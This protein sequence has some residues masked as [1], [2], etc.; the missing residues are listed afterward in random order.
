MT[1][2]ATAS[3]SSVAAQHLDAAI[4]RSEA[5]TAHLKALRN[6]NLKCTAIACYKCRT[7]HQINSL[8]Y[9]Q[10]YYYIQPSGCTDGDYYKQGEGSWD[11]PS[12]GRRNRLYDKPEITKLKPLF[13]SVRDCYCKHTMFSVA[14]DDCRKVGAGQ[15][16]ILVR[17]V[18]VA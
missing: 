7:G 12:C 2:P 18:T 8:V 16:G 13:A 17:R 6:A 9:I 10:T 15:D 4:A 11:C 14:C 5:R 1:P 3:F